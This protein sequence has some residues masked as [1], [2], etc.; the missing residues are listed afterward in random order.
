MILEEKSVREA[1]ETRYREQDRY[2]ERSRRDDSDDQYDLDDKIDEKNQVYRLNLAIKS[3]EVIGQILRNHYG[4]LEIDSKIELGEEAYNIGLRSLNSLFDLFIKDK[5]VI[6]SKIETILKEDKIT[7]RMEIEKESRKILFF[8]NCIISDFFIDKI[9]SAMG[10]EHLSE[11][12]RKILKKNDTVAFKL[13]DIAI[14]LNML[15]K[16][17]YGEIEELLK[18]IKN[19]SLPYTLLRK[20][21]INYLYMFPVDYGERERICQ[22]LNI[23]MVYVQK[24]IQRLLAQERKR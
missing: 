11:T 10:S 13:I 4:S 18:E 21:V 6:V 7:D 16:Y 24:K 9:A 19:N 8:I 2:E 23:S 17:P 3:I 22:K 12:L 20:L 15:R 1:R 14:K 5:E